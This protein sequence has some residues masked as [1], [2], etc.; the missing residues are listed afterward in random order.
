M[1]H[2]ASL[3]RNVKACVMQQ[4]EKDEMSPPNPAIQDN[5]KPKVN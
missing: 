3:I 4:Y 5:I 1:A 2:G